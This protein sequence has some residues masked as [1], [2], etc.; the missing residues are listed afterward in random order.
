M[1]QASIPVVDLFAGPG[2]L[3][4]GFSAVRN[5]SGERVFDVR[6]SIEK[7]PIAHRTL[8]LRALYRAFPKERVP[9]CYYE[10]IRNFITRDQLLANPA[11]AF[12]AERAEDEARNATLGETP[13]AEIDEWIKRAIG[14]VDP[15]VLIGGPPVR[16]TQLQVAH[17]CVALIRRRSKRTSGI[18]SIENICALFGGSA[19][20][21]L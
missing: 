7:D 21:F 1:K 10:Y 4:E 5:A 20:P 15:W 8:F 2:G 14:G 16:H 19:P 12:A 6:V 9:D 18:F 11:V 13:A 17:E 3:A